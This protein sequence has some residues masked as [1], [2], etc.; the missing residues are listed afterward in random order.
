MDGVEAKSVHVIRE[1]AG[2]AD[3]RNN[4]ELLARNPQF[5]E[6]GLDGR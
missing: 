2:A 5:G 6:D 4:Y 1:A 3:P